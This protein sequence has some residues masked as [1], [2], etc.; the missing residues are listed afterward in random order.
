MVLHTA[1]HGVET[2]DN[3]LN[4]SV[5]YIS[6]ESSGFSRTVSDWS[7][8]EGNDSALVVSTMQLPVESVSAQGWVRPISLDDQSAFQDDPNDKMTA[9]WWHNFSI[10]EATEL[11]I[12]MDSYDSSDL[13]LFLFRDDDGDGVFSSGEEVTRSWSGTSSESI[14]QTNPQDG[15]Y[16]VA[17]HGWSVDGESSRFWIDIEVVAGSS[18]EVPSFHNLNESSI[19]STWPSGSESLGGMVP[20][21]ALELNLSFLRPPDE[22]NWTGF[23]DIVLEG[24]AMIR[25]PYEYELIEL[26]PEISFTTPEDQTEANSQVP[27]NL[28]AMDIGVGFN[29]SAL[30]WTWPGNNTTFPANSAWGLATNGSLH[31]LTHVWNGIVNE[32]APPLL[33]EAWVNATLPATEQ[34]FQFQASVSDASGRHAESHLA[35][36][37]DAT[38]PMLAVHGVPWISVSSTLEF[39]IQTEPGALLVLDGEVIPTNSTG[40]ANIT[41]ELEVSSLG[42]HEDSD[43]DYFFY[44][45]AGQND[46][47]ITSTD[48]AGN[49]ANT[50]F[51]VVHDPNPPSDVSLISIKDQASYSYGQDDL[52][53]PINITSG[54]LILEIPAD[55]MEW[56]VFI[57]YFSWVQTSDC[58]LEE[59]LPPVLNESTGFP[60]PGNSQYP[61]TR[62]VS[63]PLELDGLGE[64]EIG[65]TITLEDWAG[66]SYQHNWSL[67][68]DSTPPDVS[69]A[70]SPSNGDA[71]EDHFQNLSWWSSEDV[72][73]WVSVNGEAL[74]EQFGSEGVQ[75]IILNT[76][77][78]QAFCIHATDRTIEQE[79]RN[80]FHECRIFELPESSYD[81]AISGDNQPLVSLDSVEIL[82]DRHHSQEVRWTSLTTGET[83]VIGPGEGTSFLSL[84]LV[85]GTND[86]VI[87]I[88][89]LDS[90]DSYS[91][92]I[93]RDSTPPDLEFNEEP[94]QGSTLTTL[95]EVSGHCEEGLLVR[96]SSQVQSRDIICPEGGQF[97][98]N[99]TVPGDAGQHVIEGFSM[100][101]AK[102]T[103]YYQIEVLKQDWIDW[104]IDDAQSSG[105]ML[106]VF[107][108]GAVSVFSA[109]VVFTLRISGRRA[110][111]T[112]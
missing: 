40:F 91:V 64:G 25:L 76:T 112:E 104:A 80:S 48:N 66:N 94:Y 7:E 69:W 14:S 15:L 12:S 96:I 89:S 11:S 52:Q 32:T 5:G 39:Q 82:L 97:S 55:A 75:S 57:L 56:C 17:V 107:S 77:G 13:D 59:E 43:D 54:E 88:D 85:E 29:I 26:D 79:N 67:V 93:D 42:I 100:D 81:T 8:S 24:G 60:M 38:S 83:G 33:R 22:G 27:I 1:L 30:S 44:H 4:I 70:L 71:L 103:Q 111:G 21:G 74:T 105:A 98:I 109:I 95:R 78:T 63:V 61:S 86:F 45:N 73:L 37:Y 101:H 19:A 2:N 31:D 90:T 110:R 10:E 36:S 49:S 51:Q 34:W 72:S 23:I 28:H 35:V 106:W 18:L 3:P 108:A 41:T 65:I 16:G 20:E 53:F 6:A 92:S 99:I 58:T 84:D 9:S 46:F 50:S 68:M 102:N 62:V 87:E 47:S